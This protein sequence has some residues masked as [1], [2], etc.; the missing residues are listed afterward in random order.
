MGECGGYEMTESNP[1]GNLSGLL[2]Q[3]RGM[4]QKMKEIQERS[5]NLEFEANSGGGMVTARVNGRQ[6]V[7]SVRI[8]PQAV[9]PRDV[10]MLE[11]LIVSAVNMAL[12]ESRDAVAK[13]L[14]KATGGLQIPGLSL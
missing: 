11:D 13:E 4:Q 8:E 9:D 1:F 7:L 10:E 12:H 3:A 5:G 14:Q 2:E 6:E